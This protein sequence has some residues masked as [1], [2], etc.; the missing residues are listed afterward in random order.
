MVKDWTRLD[1]DPRPCEFRPCSYLFRPLPGFGQVQSSRVESNRVQSNQVRI[2]GRGVQ[3]SPIQY[4]PVQYSPVQSIPVQSN[5]VR[6]TLTPVQ[7]SPVQ[8]SRIIRIQYSPVESS[9]SSHQG[10][11]PLHHNGPRHRCF[12]YFLIY[13]STAVIRW[14]V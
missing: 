13:D 3:T 6:I 4:S 11:P 7:Y 12:F 5:Q 2:K 10:S 9:P 8:S 1:D 14:R